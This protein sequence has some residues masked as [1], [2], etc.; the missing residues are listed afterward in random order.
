MQVVRA[1][2]VSFFSSTG[3][4]SSGPGASIGSACTWIVRLQIST[5]TMNSAISRGC[6]GSGDFLK[7]SITRVKSHRTT[8]TV[9]VFASRERKDAADEMELLSNSA[10][11]P[12]RW[13]LGWKSLHALACV[14]TQ[15]H[16]RLVME[17]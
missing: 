11:L 14:S 13:I 16:A 15:M 10:S 9:F 3:E 6:C 1:G 17:H 2:G 7:H 4:G 8:T 5:C 12:R